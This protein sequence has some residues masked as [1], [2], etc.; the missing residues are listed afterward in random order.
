M[1]KIQ[2]ELGLSSLSSDNNFSIV[3]TAYNRGVGGAR[4]FYRKTG[5]YVSEYSSLILQ[6]AHYLREHNTFDGIE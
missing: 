5:S 6:G 2:E 1:H 4:K 3:A